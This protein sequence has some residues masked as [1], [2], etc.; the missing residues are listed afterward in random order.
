MYSNAAIH[1]EVVEQKAFIA[2]LYGNS[3]RLVSQK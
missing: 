2:I 1:M 3:G